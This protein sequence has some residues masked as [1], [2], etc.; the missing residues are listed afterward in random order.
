[1]RHYTHLRRLKRTLMLSLSIMLLFLLPSAILATDSMPKTEASTSFAQG[2][3][4]QGFVL[5]LA[6]DA[7]LEVVRRALHKLSATVGEIGQIESP[8]PFVLYIQATPD[9]VPELKRIP[10]VLQVTPLK[11][12][13]SPSETLDAEMSSESSA[14]VLEEHDRTISSAKESQTAIRAYWLVLEPISESDRLLPLL[15]DELAALQAK[16]MVESFEPPIQDNNSLMVLAPSTSEGLLHQL[17]SVLDV[18]SE[19]STVSAQTLQSGGGHITGTVTDSNGTPLPN[20][21][22][23]V[24]QYNEEI[25]SWRLIADNDNDNDSDASGQYDVGG[26]NTGWYRVRFDDDQ[27]QYATEYYNNA[28]DLESATNVAVR[29]G[30][31]TTGI[32]ASLEDAGHITGTVSDESGNPLADIRVSVSQYN[33][34]LDDWQW[35]YFHDTDSEG[36]YDVGSLNTGTYRLRFYDFEGQYATQ[37]YDNALDIESATDIA[38]TVGQVTTGIDASLTLRGHITGTVSDESGNPL[39]NIRVR[40]YQYHEEVDYW[41]PLGFDD[42]DSEGQYDVGGLNTGT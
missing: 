4:R 21:D 2:A 14:P 22:V 15:L 19:R 8:S 10:G 25:D 26:L 34:E 39:A 28:P 1:M 29:A 40:V 16:G 9:A 6:P 35:R 33:E 17:P 23:N 30:L 36:Q 18:A 37:Y 7:D 31:T 12:S 3:L 24:Y 42:T 32:D 11:S 5:H 13:E 27:G 38:V 41:Q 20:I